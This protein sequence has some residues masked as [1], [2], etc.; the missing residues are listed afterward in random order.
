M[1]LSNKGN[2]AIN[3]EEFRAQE[4]KIDYN[5]LTSEDSGKTD[6][7]TMHLFFIYNR[8]REISITLPPS[9]ATEIAKVFSKIQGKIYNLTY[10]DVLENKEKTIQCY[11]LNSGANMY[12]GVI[13]GGLWNGVSFKATQIAGEMA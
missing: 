10:Y 6:D 3:D 4:I 12:S 1:A 7:G 5:S 11:T 13:L 2:F 9:G 8:Q